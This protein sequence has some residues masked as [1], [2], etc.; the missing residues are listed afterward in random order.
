MTHRTEWREYEALQA[1]LVDMTTHARLNGFAVIV[2]DYDGLQVPVPKAIADAHGV[3]EGQALSDEQM[4]ELT[5]A[6]VGFGK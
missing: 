4:M 1:L 3:V 6:M 5:D 2:C